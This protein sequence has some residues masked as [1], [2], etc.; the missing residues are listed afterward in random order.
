ML[1]FNNDCK[2]EDTES[3]WMVAQDCD[4]LPKYCLD[5]LERIRDFTTSRVQAHIS[6]TGDML[7]TLDSTSETDADKFVTPQVIVYADLDKGRALKKLAYNTHDKD[8]KP[9]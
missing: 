7:P 3:V 2:K 8:V 1:Q 6:I 5:T 4:S 9:E